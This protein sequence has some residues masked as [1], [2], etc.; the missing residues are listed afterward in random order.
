MRV[1]A[2]ALEAEEK[3]FAELFLGLAPQA[4]SGRCFAA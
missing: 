2:R 4:T 3:R 1:V